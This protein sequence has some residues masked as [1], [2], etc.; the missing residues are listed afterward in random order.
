MDI[1]AKEKD[2]ILL[3]LI[4]SMKQCI[5]FIEGYNKRNPNE[6]N[7][8]DIT[9]LEELNDLYKKVA[10]WKIDAECYKK[11]YKLGVYA[12]ESTR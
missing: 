3:A 8:R 6:P 7:V 4:T 10:G 11:H 2:H 5:G 1:N 12:N 9:E